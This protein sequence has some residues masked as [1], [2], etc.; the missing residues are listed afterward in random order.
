M[1][2]SGTRSPRSMYD[3]ASRPRLVPSRTA[4]RSTSPVAILG[5]PRLAA[6]LSACVPFPAPGGPSS[7]MIMI[8][9][10]QKSRRS[11]WLLRSRLESA[12]RL[13]AAESY[14]TLFHE[15]VVLPEQEM[16]VDL[17]HR[18]ERHADDDQERG[19]A[20]LE[21]N[22]DHV[23]DEHGEQRDKGEEERARESDARHHVI[24]VLGGLG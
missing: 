20:E 9:T 11:F 23:G 5:M 10:V 12:A 8:Y 13:P 1:T 22:I 21:R 2:E 19:S 17:R 14:S 4:A 24:N 16:L 15:A 3:L 6:S 7:T 18:I